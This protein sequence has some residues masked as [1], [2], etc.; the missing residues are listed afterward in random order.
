MG[1]EQ[2][3]SGEFCFYREPISG[4]FPIERADE[5]KNAPSH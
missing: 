3:S 1:A 2:D 4:A 5:D